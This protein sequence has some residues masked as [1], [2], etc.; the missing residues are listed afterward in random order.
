MQYKTRILQYSQ[1]RDTGSI[2]VV[3]VCTSSCV[4]V[5]TLCHPMH[6]TLTELAFQHMMTVKPTELK[7]QTQTVK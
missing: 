2:G 3:L 1:T 5:W 6:D 4:H 7:L